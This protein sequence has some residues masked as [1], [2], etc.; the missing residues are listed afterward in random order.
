MRKCPFCAEEIQDEAIQCRWCMEMLPTAQGQT[1]NAKEP[2]DSRAVKPHPNAK[3]Y[4]IAGFTLSLVGYLWAEILLF[5]ILGLVFS[6]LAND[7]LKAGESGKGMAIAGCILG[8]VVILLGIYI[9][10]TN[11]PEWAQ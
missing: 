3:G 6:G 1:R 5:G 9:L 7:R 10:S 2:P 8:I 11:P 4:A